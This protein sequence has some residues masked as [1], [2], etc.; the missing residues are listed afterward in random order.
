MGRRFWLLWQGQLISQLG[1]QAF[2]VAAIFWIKRQTD[3]ATLLGLVT[4][5]GSLPAVLLGPFGAVAADLY[6]RRR[7]LIGV[8]VVRGLAAAMVALLFWSGEPGQLG[9]FAVLAACVF[10]GGGDAFFRPAIGATIPDILPAEKLTRG[11]ALNRLAID[12]ATFLGQA[13]GALFFR[14]F[15]PFWLFLVN[16]LSY[17]WGATSVVLAGPLSQ[18]PRGERKLGLWAE[19]RSGFAA[20][21][22]R[23]GIA[24]IMMLAPLDTFFAVSIVVLLPFFVEDQ[25]KVNADWYGFLIAGFGAGSFVGSLLAGFL[26]M[27]GTRRRNAVLTSSFCF[28]A[29]AGSL[30]FATSPYLAVGLMAL[31]GVF[32]GFNMIQIVTA[33]Q[34][35]APAESR[36]RILGLFETLSIS[37][38]PVAAG[39]IGPVADLLDRNIPLIY[40]ICG[41]GLAVVAIIWLFDPS[42]RAFLASNRDEVEAA[43][44][45]TATDPAA[46]P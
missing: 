35:E 19:L 5:A 3:S 39:L 41:A 11:N 30:G 9:V 2:G 23:P 29:C 24:R 10:L 15:G 34:L 21:R 22:S 8:D 18:A 44:S 40:G 32:L 36:G 16:S 13:T 27:R 14:L 7:I 38:A 33:L 26:R 17:F 6:S 28:S 43:G 42:I 4:V 1:G 20:A 12:T 31:G 46:L 45:T 37:A 25:L